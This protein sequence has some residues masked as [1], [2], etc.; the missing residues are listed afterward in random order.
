MISHLSVLNIYIFF[1]FKCALLNDILYFVITYRHALGRKCLI[2]IGLSCVFLVL[3]ILVPIIVLSHVS[4]ILLSL[5][6]PFSI[7]LVT[8]RIFSNIMRNLF[9]VLEGQKVGCVLDSCAY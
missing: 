1:P 2:A 9:T 4:R 3:L 5:K 7:Y 8:Y 6:I